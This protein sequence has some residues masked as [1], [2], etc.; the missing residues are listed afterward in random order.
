MNRF[1]ANI[2]FKGISLIVLSGL[3]VLLGWNRFEESSTAFAQDSSAPTL[4]VTGKGSESIETSLTEIRLGV[5]VEGKTAREVQEESAQRSTAVVKLLRSRN[6][7]N[8][9]TTGIRLQPQ[10]DY[11]DGTRTLKG[12]QALNLVSF[13]VVT[14]EIGNLL[15]EAVNV[16]ATRID[17]V[18]FTATDSA[19]EQA[20]KQA[21]RTATR[22]A[23]AQADTVLETLNLRSQSVINIQIDGANP[24]VSPRIQSL[25]TRG[26]MTTSSAAN[27]PVIGG[28]Q[29]IE[30]Q[31]TLQIRY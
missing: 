19:I 27:S 16:G 22:N 2:W 21:L 12:Y 29:E 18:T 7:Q 20:Q 4:T 6:V 30:A 14:E 17:S 5:E 28:E 13:R 31:V 9:E 11:N 23:K 26:D 24:S 1:F 10:Y 15:D 25:R 3:I 8:L